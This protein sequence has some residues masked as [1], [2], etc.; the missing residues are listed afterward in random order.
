MSPM[1]A[2]YA[3]YLAI[4]LTVTVWVGRSLFRAGRVFLVE[5]FAGDTALADAIN[6]LLLVG[7]Y[8]VN[9]AFLTLALKTASRASSLVEAIEL[10]GDK[11]GLVLLV[12]GSMHFITVAV[13]AR[14]R[15]NTV[16]PPTT[17]PAYLR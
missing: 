15:R 5:I 6:R 1:A 17:S 8:L 10:L 13:L 14:S 9:T 4:T 7:Y 11:V 12:L 16:T 3:V 2:T